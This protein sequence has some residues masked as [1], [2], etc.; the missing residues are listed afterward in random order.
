MKDLGECSLKNLLTTAWENEYDNGI[1]LPGTETEIHLVF[2][3]AFS[4]FAYVKDPDG[5]C[6]ELLP[7]NMS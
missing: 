4:Q 2:K 7:Q 5:Y 1:E 6:V 3:Q